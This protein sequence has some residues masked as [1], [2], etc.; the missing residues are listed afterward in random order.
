MITQN[1]CVWRY[2]GDECGYSGGPV[3]DEHNNPISTGSAN[4]S[5]ERAYNAALKDYEDK[6]RIYK[7]KLAER[8][9]QRTRENLACQTEGGESFGGFN[10]TKSQQ[11]YVR[12]AGHE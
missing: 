2:R 9:A 10:E 7:E 12:L 3:A 6:R 11:N 8:S 4:T 5:E 1:H